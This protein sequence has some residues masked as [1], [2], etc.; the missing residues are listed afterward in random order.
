MERIHQGHK[1]GTKPEASRPQS[2][3][4]K[5]LRHP[6]HATRV[7]GWQSPRT[8]RA[9][10]RGRGTPR[11][12]SLLL[13]RPQACAAASRCGAQQ[14]GERLQRGAVT[15]HLGGL[16]CNREPGAA[17]PAGLI[18]AASRRLGTQVRLPVAPRSGDS[19]P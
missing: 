15:E 17:H 19:A 14:S 9:L 6:A 11:S 3:F 13:L 10:P 16:L 18:P 1:V 5:W 8:E 12:L 2:S 7:T 4:V